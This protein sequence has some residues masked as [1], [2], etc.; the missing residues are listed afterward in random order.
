MKDYTEKEPTLSKYSLLIFFTLSFALMI[1]GVS[2]K[3]FLSVPDFVS[4]AISI[5]SPTISTVILSVF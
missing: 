5:W 4:Q 3:I 2:L 1:L